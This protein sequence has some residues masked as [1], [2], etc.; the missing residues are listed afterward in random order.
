MKKQ[1]AALGCIALLVFALPIGVLVYLI[2]GD[3]MMSGME[4]FGC[5][6]R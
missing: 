5:S 1:I 6:Y 4:S 2:K 3:E